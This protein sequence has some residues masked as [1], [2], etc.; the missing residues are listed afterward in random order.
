MGAVQA[1]RSSSQRAALIDAVSIGP[2]PTIRNSVQAT[3][4]TTSRPLTPT[5][6]HGLSWLTTAVDE[7][8]TRCAG[9]QDGSSPP[10]QAA[11]VSGVERYT[12]TALG[13]SASG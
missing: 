7:A 6:S 1:L 12:V 10:W 5:S 9:Q 11:S 8:T 13:R 4:T 2:G 3:Q